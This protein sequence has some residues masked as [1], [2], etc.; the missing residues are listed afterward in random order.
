LV[1]MTDE[2]SYSLLSPTTLLVTLV[3]CAAAWYFSRSSTP[4][5][6]D[7]DEEEDHTPKGHGTDAGIDSPEDTR[8]RAASF[9]NLPAEWKEADT[10]ARSDGTKPRALNG[11]WHEPLARGFRVR[12][13]NYLKD[14]VKL[15]SEQ[16]VFSPIGV[17]TYQKGKGEKKCSHTASLG[18]LAEHIAS[19]PDEEFFVVGWMLPGKGTEASP[20][21]TAIFAFQRVMPK[22]ADAIADNLWDIMLNGTDDQKKA[23]F[24]YLPRIDVGPSMVTGSIRMMGGEKPTMLCNKLNHRFYRG[25][26]YLEIDID[27]SSSKLANMVSGLI[28]PNVAKLV[29]GHAFLIEGHTEEEL[30]ERVLA[31]CTIQG[32]TIDGNVI[33]VEPPPESKES[34]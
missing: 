29:V 12:G 22:G 21:R 3:V 2:E 11:T 15:P 31:A 9:T 8:E 28:I 24:K 27:I 33:S 20:Y 32:L 1:G 16:Q 18:G 13:K 14:R 25:P 4:A 19:R 10:S 34:K 5:E 17:H 30:P 23:R 6:A 26:N 7:E